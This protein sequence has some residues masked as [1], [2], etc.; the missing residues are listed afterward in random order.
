MRST[1]FFCSILMAFGILLFAGETDKTVANEK[2]GAESMLLSQLAT[3]DMTLALLESELQSK[4]NRIL[5]LKEQ[6]K[7]VETENRKME[8]MLEAQRILTDFQARQLNRMRQVLK[9]QRE[10]IRTLT[11]K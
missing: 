6:N 1:R 3:R 11:E 9:E 5:L 10:Q 4:D 8:R 7:Q 2:N